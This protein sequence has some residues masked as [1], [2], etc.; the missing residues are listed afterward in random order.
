MPSPRAS[1][2][3]PWFTIRTAVAEGWRVKRVVY[4]N[5]LLAFVPAIIAGGPTDVVVEANIMRAAA[6]P[7]EAASART[8]TADT[9]PR[10]VPLGEGTMWPLQP[11]TEPASAAAPVP[12]SR[13]QRPPVQEETPAWPPKSEP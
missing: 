10:A 3:N 8:P 7:R 2:V 13:A 4:L 11:Q 1:A 12:N 9:L 6:A 5:A